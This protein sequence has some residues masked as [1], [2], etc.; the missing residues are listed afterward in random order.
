MP[1][2]PL[3]SLHCRLT[4]LAVLH[5]CA[6]AQCQ[7]KPK[8]EWKENHMSFLSVIWLEQTT[9]SLQAKHLQLREVCQEERVKSLVLSAGLMQPNP[10]SK[11]FFWHPQN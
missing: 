5:R 11:T 9:A 8:E 4:F 1:L 7:R 6:P 2:H 10:N 3:H